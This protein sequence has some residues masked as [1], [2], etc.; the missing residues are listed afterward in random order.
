M[1]K[2]SVERLDEGTVRLSVT[3]SSDEVDAAIERTYKRLSEQLEVPGFRKGKVPPRVIDNVVGNLRVLSEA[4]EEILNT[5]YA[6]ALDQEALRPMD[7]PDLDDPALPSEGKEY[8]YAATVPVRPELRLRS[9]ENIRVIAP[10][11]RATDEEIERQIEHTRDRFATLEVV[12]RGIGPEDFALISFKGEIDGESFEGDSVEHYLYE[13]GSGQMPAEFEQQLIGAAA[14]ETREVRFIIP[15]TSSRKEFVGKE[16]VFQVE[17]HEVKRKVLPELDD[18]FAQTAGFDT[19][20]DMRA[21]IR[22]D[23]EKQKK[24]MRART[25]ET[26]AR[27]MLAANL[28]GDIPRAMVERRAGDII[29]DFMNFVESQGVSPEAYTMQQGITLE[30]LEREFEAEALESVRVELALEALFREL[31]LVLTDEDLAKEFGSLA[32]GDIDKDEVRTRIEKAG[33][34]S[35]IREQVMQRKAVEWLMENIEIIEEDELSDDGPD[36][37]DGE[38]EPQGAEARSGSEADAGPSEEE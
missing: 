26:E 20:E 17:I 1:L 18:E 27:R 3:V 6:R 16:A 7:K 11:T 22:E 29:R 32:G 31:G 10:S 38:D 24:V 34:M 25:I 33:M 2:T 5:T 28:E 14:G 36:T 35:L 4:Q 9:Y 12:E 8:S 19:L 21:K 23:I 30:D 15:P 13:F 37:S